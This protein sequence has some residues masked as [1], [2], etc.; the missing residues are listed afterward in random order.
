MFDSPIDDMSTMDTG[1]DRRQGAFDLRQH[2]SMYGL[3]DMSLLWTD[4][5]PLPERPGLLAKRQRKLK[6]LYLKGKYIYHYRFSYK[7]Q[8]YKVVE[9]RNRKF[10]VNAN[11]KKV[12][13]YRNPHF[14]TYFQ[15][16]FQK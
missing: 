14:F 9:M 4:F 3:I 8:N 1:P 6:R 11:S 2:A 13:K 15:K 10:V 7:G 12:Y 5:T 16:K